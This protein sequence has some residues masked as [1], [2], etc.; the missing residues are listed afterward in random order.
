MLRVRAGGRLL[1]SRRGLAG[2]D[3]RRS[4]PEDDEPIRL[5]HESVIQRLAAYRR[6]TGTTATA[7]LVDL[8]HVEPRADVVV[9]PEAGEP[10]DR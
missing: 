9:I 1:R 8:T 4:L 6:R 3:E 7:E 10:K 2:M 5:E